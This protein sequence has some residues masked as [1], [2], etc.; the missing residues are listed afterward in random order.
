LTPIPF[1]YSSM[2]NAHLLISPGFEERVLNLIS[3][4]NSVTKVSHFYQR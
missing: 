3:S 1:R 4:F 2:N